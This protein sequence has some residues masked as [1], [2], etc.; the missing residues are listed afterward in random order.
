MGCGYNLCVSQ[1]SS[2]CRISML[3]HIARMCMSLEGYFRSLYWK[4]IQNL[5]DKDMAVFISAVAANHKSER[6]SDY[7][8]DKYS[9]KSIFLGHWIIVHL[10]DCLSSLCCFHIHIQNSKEISAR[11][12][13]YTCV[14]N[15]LPACPSIWHYKSHAPNVCVR[16][17]SYCLFLICCVTRRAVV[18]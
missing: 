10:V 3:T 7:I 1:N 17:R 13:V 18:H 16:P 9:H 6:H 11:W 2:P 12:I 8:I 14:P 5:S 15:F 4:W